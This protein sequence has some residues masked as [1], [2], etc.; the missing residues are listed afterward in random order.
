[1]SKAVDIAKASTTGSFHLLWGLVISTLISSIGTIFIARLLGSDLY[2]LY[3]IVLIVPTIMQ[4]FRDWGINSAMIRFTAQYR[5]EGRF[6]EIRSIFLTGIIFEVI[7]GLLLSV[8]SFFSADFL[9]ITVFNRPLL[10][11]FIQIASFSIFASGL[12]TAATAVF[13]GYERMALNSIMIVGQNIAKTAI[14]IVLVAFGM[15]TAGATIGYTVGLFIASIIG[16]SLVSVIYRSLPKPVSKQLHLK[17]YL[18]TMLSYCLPLSFGIIITT[19]LPQF[20]A[21][22]LPIHY[23]TDNVPIGNYGIALNFVVLIGFFTM[24]ISTMMFPAFS[25]LDAEK[26]KVDLGNIF[27]FSVKYA[28]LIVVP[29]TFLVMSLAGPGVETLFGETYVLAPLFLTLMSIQYLYAAFGNLSVSGFLN[30]QGKTSYVLKLSLLTG[31]IGFP[32]GYFLIMNY[33]VLGLIITTLTAGLPSIFM[34]LRFIKKTYNIGLDWVSS[35]KILLSS[36]VA[37]LLTYLVVAA[38]PLA[39][40]LLLVVGVPFFVVVV[41]AALLFTRSITQSD[42][43]ALR[44]M[45]KGLGSFSR[46]INKLLI[47]LE[48]LMKLLGKQG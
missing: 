24:P 31:T 18:T 40:W 46:F 2:G 4:V 41:L 26:D 7:L 13:T 30:G 5:A 28:S 17:E 12:V 10:A 14:I 19:L 11:P 25:K 44:S 21:F 42:V 23:V 8:L 37:G 15:G 38:L 36:A 27:R 9:A 1:M 22:L 34:G 20:Y 29:V 48:K 16:I 47:I 33:G 45:V 32:V 6:D 43:V 35:V 3:T 39:S